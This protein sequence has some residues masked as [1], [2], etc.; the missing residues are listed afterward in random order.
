MSIIGSRYDDCCVVARP[1]QAEHPAMDARAP[2]WRLAGQSCGCCR[3]EGGEFIGIRLACGRYAN[4][5]DS[6]FRTIYA[7]L[8]KEL[9]PEIQSLKS[10]DPWCRLSS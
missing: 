6:V 3:A 1:K 9:V 10:L 8:P 7:F 2:F 5:C 4:E